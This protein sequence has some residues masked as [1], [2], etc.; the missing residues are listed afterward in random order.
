MLFLLTWRVHIINI[1]VNS[2]FPVKPSDPSKVLVFEDAPNGGRAAVA[3][4]MKCVMVPN[5]RWRQEAMKI[6]LL[7]KYCIVL[8]N[9][10]QKNSVFLLSID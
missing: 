10:V 3:A 7:R 2:R 9:F 6:G 1:N 5:E 8:K 4:G